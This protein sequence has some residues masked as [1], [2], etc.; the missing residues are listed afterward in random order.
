MKFYRFNGAI[1]L[2]LFIVLTF[3]GIVF[4]Q[5]Y[6]VEPYRI[7]EVLKTGMGQTSSI[8]D[9]DVVFKTED[10]G[11]SAILGNGVINDFG[12]THDGVYFVILTSVGYEVFNARTDNYQI[13]KKVITDKNYTK[14]S[15]TDDSRFLVLG[16]KDGSVDKW[17][18]EGNS[19]VPL[20]KQ[21]EA[22]TS[23]AISSDGRYTATGMNNGTV[24]L[25]NSYNSK[26]TTINIHSG[27]VKA[28]AF[29][30]GCDKL[31]SGGVDG[32]VWEYKIEEDQKKKVYQS[33]DW[34]L[35]LQ[36][37]PMKNVN[38]LAIATSFNKVL[39]LDLDREKISEDSINY[40]SM[41]LHNGW[42]NAID[43][44]EDGKILF[45]SS[46]DTT[47]G[48]WY[49][50]ENRAMINTKYS[51]PANNISCAKSIGSS[52]R[53]NVAVGYDNNIIKIF[54]FNFKKNKI[55]S[56]KTLNAHS[57]PIDQ[58]VISPDTNL[59]FV[60]HGDNRIV[61]WSYDNQSGKFIKD[62]LT[63]HKEK[64]ND[65]DYAQT[66]REAFLVSCSEDRTAKVYSALTSETFTINEHN[67]PVKACAVY[68]NRIDN[69]YM[70]ATASKKKLVLTD[71]TLIGQPDASKTFMAKE[72]IVELDFSPD[73]EIIAVGEKDGTI[74][75]MSWFEDNPEFVTIGKHSGRITS[76]EYSQ[77]SNDFIYTSATDK[78]VKKLSFSARKSLQDIRV[79]SIPTSLSI[80]KQDSMLLIGMKDGSIKKWLLI[81]KQLES[82]KSYSG[83]VSD[84]VFVLS[85]LVIV[86]G[87]D[88]VV[89]LLGTKLATQKAVDP[90]VWKKKFPRHITTKLLLHDKKLYFGTADGYVCCIK[91]KQ[92]KET[93]T[94]DTVFEYKTE[95]NGRIDCELFLDEA[96][97]IIYFGN[98]SK[99]FFAISTNGKEIWKKNMDSVI[100]HHV[101]CVKDGDYLFVPMFDV[102]T[103]QDL[104]DQGKA[105]NRRLV[106]A[107]N[108]STPV[109][110]DN[111]VYIGA[112]NS[113]VYAYDK[114]TDSVDTV[115]NGT[116]MNN[117][118]GRIY[119]TEL[120]TLADN[121]I[122]NDTAGNICAFPLVAEGPGI[123]PEWSYR[124]GNIEGK[125][126]VDDK[127]I[128][129]GDE[130]GTLYKLE[131][132]KDEPLWTSVIGRD[133]F[134]PIISH[135]QIRTEDNP[136]EMQDVILVSN[137]TPSVKVVLKSDG[138]IIWEFDDL[139][140]TCRRP[141]E[142][143]DPFL[144][145]YT[146]NDVIY[147]L[148]TNA[149]MF[150]E[151]DDDWDDD[152][153]PSQPTGGFASATDSITN[154]SS[155]TDS[156]VSTN[157]TWDDDDDD[158]WDDDDDDDDWDDD[159][160][161]WNIE[162]E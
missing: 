121:L 93:E 113:S 159:D 29:T 131:I 8:N 53:M 80:D 73:G 116:T 28:L 158:D 25:H 119:Q 161:D 146:T 100:R 132:G 27:E 130:S 138:E 33:S 77:Q 125:I 65:I 86:G 38:H 106:S 58:L 96:T 50:P 104:R 112:E 64:I 63:L 23:I 133:G 82:F 134:F 153:E 32:S 94:F 36:I 118:T 91:T 12:Y 56:E 160:D 157:D 31:L 69:I 105:L 19:F 126:L 67:D 117:P 30:I 66:T 129:A 111:M 89:R 4:L 88:G 162:N 83:S 46:N 143:S 72:E 24:Y 76:L 99:W 21:S 3:S 97:N 22:V 26:L 155:S 145:L 2:A 47:F 48:C 156:D 87:S 137:N 142:M 61:V 75:A 136:A 44:S 34:I 107:N 147:K 144:Y 42:I 128:Y 52:D 35:D 62:V 41:G 79:N 141:I 13:Y 7:S 45:T 14:M 152:D 17:D 140:E 60:T 122:V 154:G 95:P 92:K 49:L 120:Y 68:A 101:R 70:V 11:L 81:N 57:L 108:Y 85:D 78:V 6:G 148:T 84:V 127:Y 39:L 123:Q 1:V 10:K 5:D 114:A 55:L 135:G 151:E 74:E 124:I 109:V 59:L 150:D 16:S 43:F 54:D 90:V 139:D 37:R 40:E 9:P 71:L 51:F 110:H 102:L 149:K 103:R 20:Y 18:I 115:W 98:E 15:I